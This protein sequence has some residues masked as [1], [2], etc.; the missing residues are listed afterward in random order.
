M[1]SSFADGVPVGAEVY[2]SQVAETYTA[3]EP[4]VNRA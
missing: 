3:G 4:A 2:P 1:S